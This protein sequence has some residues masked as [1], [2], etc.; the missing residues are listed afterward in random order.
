LHKLRTTNLRH[1]PKRTFVIF[2]LFPCLVGKELCGCQLAK[3]LLL[4]IQ[5]HQDFLRITWCDGFDARGCLHW[6]VHLLITCRVE[7]H[8]FAWSFVSHVG[9]RSFLV[10]FQAV[11]SGARGVQG[12]PLP[13]KNFAWAPQWAPK[14]SGLFLKVLHRSLTASLV[15]K[16]APPVDPQMKMSG[17]APAGGCCVTLQML[18]RAG[19]LRCKYFVRR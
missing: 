16:L 1:Q 2:L 10:S 4:A 5:A 8:C 11:W 19:V 3:W 6:L 15:A 9:I 14:F 13:P 12:E 18:M 17:S 7:L